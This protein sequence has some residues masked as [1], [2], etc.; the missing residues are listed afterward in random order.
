MVKADA[1]SGARLM[2]CLISRVCTQTRD[3]D[4]VLIFEECM[5]GFAAAFVLNE[6]R[7]QAPLPLTGLGARKCKESR[8]SH[9]HAL[10]AFLS[11]SA[12]VGGCLGASGA[13]GESQW[14]AA[15]VIV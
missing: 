8:Q 1:R 6:R 3:S 11:V 13:R 9:C 15:T 12:C 7:R 5:Q 10:T 4:N 2:T 14:K